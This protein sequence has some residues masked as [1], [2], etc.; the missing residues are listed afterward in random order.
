[1]TENPYQPECCHG[2]ES[3]RFFAETLWAL[4][5]TFADSIAVHPYDMADTIDR[6]V[7]PSCQSEQLAECE[8]ELLLDATEVEGD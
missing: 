4:P 2:C 7:K 8:K 6:L 3:V 1:M 5:K